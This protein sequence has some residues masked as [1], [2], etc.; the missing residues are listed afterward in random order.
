MQ[1]SDIAI[2]IEGLSKR[3]RIGRRPT[4][5]RTLREAIV[6]A[7]SAPARRLSRGL[8]PPADDVIWAL[9]H[10]ELEVQRGD[11]LGIIGPNGA[12]KSTLLKILSRITEPTEGRVEI[13]GRVGALLEVG[14]GFH[15]ELTGRENIYLNG[16]ILGMTRR[17]IRAKFDE[18]VDFAEVDAFLDTPIKR[19]STGMGTRLAFAIAAHLEP[20]ILAVDEVLSVG[21]AAFQRKCLGKMSSVASEGRTVLFVSHNMQ[22]IQSLCKRA[23]H[24]ERGRIVNDGDPRSVVAHYLADAGS[25]TCEVRWAEPEAPGN[26]EVRLTSIRARAANG[27]SSGVYSTSD[28][29]VV[30]MDFTATKTPSALCVGFDLLTAEG[31]TLFRTYQTDLAPDEWPRLRVG[32]NC[33]QCTVRGGLLNAGVYYICPRIGI[34]NLYWIVK[35]DA[36]VQLE[37][38]LD[39]GV[40]PFWNTLDAR[41]RPG[42]IAP[43]LSWR[44]AT[45]E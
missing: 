3:Y 23:V 4:R 40:S 7:V 24:L 5:Y 45:V 33:W 37:L 38:V 42:L 16:A 25:A 8:R 18:I 15:P 14:T 22:P 1:S 30:E 12:G 6:D 19:Y 28:D 41:N 26:D 27:S 13:K 43:I 10:V 36:V 35:L 11:V 31:T 29:L 20:E 32:R 2:R 34:H 44:A 39:H 9:K 17:E 21:D